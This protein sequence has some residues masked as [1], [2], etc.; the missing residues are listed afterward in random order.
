[1]IWE[2]ASDTGGDLS[3]LMAIDQTIKAGNCD[4]K[5]FFKDSDGD[6]FGDLN[7]PIEACEAPPGYVSDSRDTDDS[8]ARKHP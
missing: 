3:L 6:G 7:K 2:I 1:M 8:D 5:T 4:V